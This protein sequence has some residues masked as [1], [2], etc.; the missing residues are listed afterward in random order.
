MD[1]QPGPLLLDSIRRDRKLSSI[2]SAGT[3]W[4]EG[5]QEP[6]SVHEVREGWHV[7]EAEYEAVGLALHVAEPFQ[8][9]Y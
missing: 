4:L 5:R 3:D 7:P 8:P 9:N 1:W 2:S 6:C